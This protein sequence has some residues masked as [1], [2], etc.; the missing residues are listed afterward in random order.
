MAVLSVG[1]AAPDF[2]LPGNGR[3]PI[4]L[5]DLRGKP[6]VIYFYP[7]DG[8]ETCTAQAIDFS[9]LMPKFKAAGVQVIGISPDNS[10]SHAKFR[11]KHGLKVDLAADTEK[12]AV[13]AYGVWLP[14]VLFG[15]EYMGIERS[16]FLVDA[17]GRIAA[18]WRKVRIKGHAAATLQAAQALPPAA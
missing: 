6:V 16:T 17:H 18:I 3:R 8:S 13:E 10:A 9:R 1:D 15:R 4:K 7:S 12:Q 11:K 14:K 2:N 5:S